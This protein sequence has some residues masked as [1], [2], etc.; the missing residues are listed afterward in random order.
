MVAVLYLARD[1]L[2]GP[3][4]AATVG[5]GFAASSGPRTFDKLG[6]SRAVWQARSH[7]LAL[8]LPL[9]STFYE[10]TPSPTQSDEVVNVNAVSEAVSTVSMPPRMRFAPWSPM[11][12]N[13]SPRSFDSV[14]SDTL[15]DL[16]R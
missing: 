10:R 7:D 16:T 8:T 4:A 11:P 2:G 9:Y 1:V 5:G 15:A 6:V 3:S 14:L 13:W 12:A